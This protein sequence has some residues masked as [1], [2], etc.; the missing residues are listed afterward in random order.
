MRE[1]ADGRVKQHELRLGSE[2]KIGQEKAGKL[3]RLCNTDRK[4]KRGKGKNMQTTNESPTVCG[5]DLS[6]RSIKTFIMTRSH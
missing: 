4:E 5:P 1:E 2:N 6:L 3:D